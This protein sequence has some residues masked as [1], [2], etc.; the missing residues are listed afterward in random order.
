[1]EA[2]V[3][4]GVDCLALETQPKLSEVKA[5]LDLLKNEYPDQK[6]YVSFTL[7]NAETISEGTKLVDAAKAVAQYDQVIGVGVNCIP[8]RLVTPAIK[9]LKEATALPIIV[10]PNSGASYDATTKTL[11]LIHI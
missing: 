2:I 3:N 1:M 7:Q 10:Y 5:V 4:A 8:P 9:K 6:V 11:S